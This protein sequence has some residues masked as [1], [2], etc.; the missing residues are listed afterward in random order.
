MLYAVLRAISKL[1]LRWYYREIRVRDVNRIPRN[2][3]V[4]F[5]VNHPNALID[6]LVAGTTIPRRV[7][8]TG[9]ATLF[10]N[11]FLA[12]LLRSVGFIPLRRA[13]DERAAMREGRGG[14]DAAR[15][16]NAESFRAITEHLR[17]QGAV[18]VFPEGKSH[19]EPRL[20]PLR[21]GIAR[22]ALD[23]ARA[24]VQPLTIV[25]IGLVFE[26][27]E[28]PRSRVAVQVGEPLPLVPGALPTVESLMAHLD[29][30]LRA[31]TLNFDTVEEEARLVDV[32][33]TLAAGLQ[34][35]RRLPESDVSLTAV[36]DVIRRVERVRD[37]LPRVDVGDVVTPRARHLFDEIAAYRDQLRTLRI[38]PSD[39]EIPTGVGAGARFAL[40]EGLLAIVGTPAALWGRVN[41]WIALRLARFIAL[42]G[43]DPAL[44]MDQPAMRTVVIGLVLVL[45]S[46]VTQTA[47]V[48]W[49]FGSVWALLYLVSLPLTATWDFTL[50]DRFARARERMH[51]YRLFRRDPELHRRLCLELDSLRTEAAEIERAVISPGGAGMD[52]PGPS[53]TP[54]DVRQFAGP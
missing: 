28:R 53:A 10:E 45:L 26:R 14:L 20:A 5:A 25:P 46:Y 9:K 15:E 31:V 50:A 35:P 13:S 44:G 42:R 4:L 27:K 30:E 48:G 36:L 39:V 8:L 23:A 52:R 29:A 7:T 47:L 32:A 33:E 43:A 22:M 37:A 41:H 24:G 49:L 2:G 34:A 18:L 40:R 38:A 11:P 17:S 51:A 3:A 21:T 12:A 1:A 6:A 54:H 19:D 16:R